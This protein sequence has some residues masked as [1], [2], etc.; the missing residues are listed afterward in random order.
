MRRVFSALGVLAVI[1]LPGD[2]AAQHVASV[3]AE[4]HQAAT[5]DWVKYR[6]KNSKME[7]T[8]RYALL[9]E[10]AGAAPG[11]W[12]EIEGDIQAPQ[13][14]HSIMQ[15]G[16]EGW[17][18]DKADVAGTVVKVEGRPPLKL[19][20]GMVERIR[21]QQASPIGDYSHVCTDAEMIGRET[22]QVAAGTFRAFELQLPGEDGGRIWL[23]ADAPFGLVKGENPD[24]T[25]EL[26]DSGTD[27]TSQITG[28]PRERPAVAGGE[29]GRDAP[30]A[31]PRSSDQP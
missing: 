23:S 20:D 11:P 13:P 10:G 9:A 6:V 21:Q 12:F 17:P 25:I 14:R 26:V 22:V 15:L 30:A 5:G 1:T 27:A 4:V 8:M 19:P 29:P 3:C 24:G 7:G 2:V 28:A 16:V 18:F 31:D